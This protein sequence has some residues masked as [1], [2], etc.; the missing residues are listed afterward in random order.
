MRI[1]HPLYRHEFN[2]AENGDVV[3]EV[4]G[5]ERSLIYRTAL[6]TGFRAGAVASY[7]ES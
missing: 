3:V 4:T 1:F 7:Q 2:E 6:F 5:K